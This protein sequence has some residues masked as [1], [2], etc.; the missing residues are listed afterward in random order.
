MQLQKFRETHNL[1]RWV[2]N[3]ENEKFSYKWASKLSLNVMPIY[4][5]DCLEKFEDVKSSIKSNPQS[6]NIWMKVKQVLS[7]LNFSSYIES[8][9]E[10]FSKLNVSLNYFGDM[11]IYYFIT[12]L[13]FQVHLLAFKSIILKDL[14]FLFIPFMRCLSWAWKPNHSWKPIILLFF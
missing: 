9:V 13:L 14:S 4:G 7:V 10:K 5:V 1:I 3:L 6:L 12:T 2:L 8:F 11:N